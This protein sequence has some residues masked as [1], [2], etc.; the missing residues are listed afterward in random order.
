MF[1]APPPVAIFGNTQPSHA[2]GKRI[3][4]KE[5]AMYL[6]TNIRAIPK[7]VNAPMNVKAALKR[8]SIILIISAKRFLSVKKQLKKGAY[9]LKKT[10][11]RGISIKG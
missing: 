5:R 8:T 10:R 3:I 7:R 2:N 11:E 4:K 9:T 6:Y 1:L